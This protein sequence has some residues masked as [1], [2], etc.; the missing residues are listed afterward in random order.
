ME[1]AVRRRWGWDEWLTWAVGDGGSGTCEGELAAGGGR[2]AGPLRSRRALLQSGGGSGGSGDDSLL[3]APHGASHPL[4]NQSALQELQA[5]AFGCSG[6]EGIEAKAVSKG[7]LG[8]IVYHKEWAKIKCAAPAEAGDLENPECGDLQHDGSDGVVVPDVGGVVCCNEA[9]G[10]PEDSREDNPDS[11]G[12]IG[13]LPDISP[14]GITG[15]RVVESNAGSVNGVPYAPVDDKSD[16]D[17]NISPSMAENQGVSGDV[18]LSK[19][20]VLVVGDRNCC[21]IG[22]DVIGPRGNLDAGDKGL[23]GDALNGETLHHY[24]APPSPQWVLEP[25]T[26]AVADPE[27]NGGDG[28]FEAVKKQL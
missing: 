9:N 5:D 18:G 24:P 8:R 1:E 19:C 13:P 10:V 2:R 25:S 26:R 11:N 12:N 4:R 28:G 6:G 14:A 16:M 20:G 17:G 23:P 7:G 3:S 15:G 21:A 22:D 27:A